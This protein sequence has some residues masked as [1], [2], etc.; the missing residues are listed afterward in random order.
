[1]VSRV[2][3]TTKQLESQNIMSVTFPYLYFQINAS[4]YHTNRENP[5]WVVY[6]P[7]FDTD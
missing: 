3:E 2:S 1:M 7:H 4:P 6:N 5:E